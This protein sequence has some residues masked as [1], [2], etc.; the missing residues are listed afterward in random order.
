MLMFIYL[1]QLISELVRLLFSLDMNGLELF[2]T[3]EGPSTMECFLFR[4]CN[5]SLDATFSSKGKT[6]LFLEEILCGISFNINVEY[7]L[8]RNRVHLAKMVDKDKCT[9]DHSLKH[10]QLDSRLAEVIA[11]LQP[12]QESEI[13]DQGFL[14]RDSVED[15]GLDD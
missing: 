1:R 9:I 4:K 13:D 12:K 11:K 6:V 5:S 7:L 3:R 10:D 2:E 8:R 14:R 15:V